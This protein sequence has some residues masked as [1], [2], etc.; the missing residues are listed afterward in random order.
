METTRKMKKKKKNN[1][2]NDKNKLRR[3]YLR[4]TV[5]TQLYFSGMYLLAVEGE[6]A[7]KNNGEKN[8]I[9]EDGLLNS[10]T[11]VVV[12]RVESAYYYAR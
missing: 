4:R 7:Y 9:H 10:E 5:L 8:I 1:N 3:P 11:L 12:H 6:E 2:N